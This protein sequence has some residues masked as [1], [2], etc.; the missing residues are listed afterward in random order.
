M[1]IALLTAL[2]EES[3]RASRKA[4][5]RPFVGRSVL[6]HQ[7]DCAR[8]LDCDMVVCM[9]R[10]LGP[11]A[12]VCQHRAESLGMRFRAIEDLRRLSG[13]ISADDRVI[14]IADGLALDI[15]TAQAAIG[16][17]PGVATFPADVAVPLGFERIDAERAWA[18]LLA[19]R[20][21]AVERLSDLPPDADAA[22][23]LLRIALQSGVRT[24]PLDLST[25]EDMAAIG[26]EDEASLSARGA[27]PVSFAAPGRAMA[28][29]I[30]IRLARDV[31]GSRFERVPLM[32]AV[33][34]GVLAAILA[35][36]GK[37]L[38][39]LL[40][41]GLMAAALP[42]ADI[43]LRLARPP[44][45]EPRM[46]HATA[47]LAGAG[48]VLLIGLI[49]MAGRVTGS[50]IDLFLPLMLMGLLRIG[51]RIAPIA[52]RPLMSDRIALLAV[53]VPAG[54]LGLLQPVVASLA[55]LALIAIYHATHADRLTAP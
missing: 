40:I 41:S 25:I 19:I 15:E 44:G 36:F 8:A 24:A 3:G 46:W 34:A 4:A 22:S 26:P 11:E 28:E 47:L 31:V 55:L 38:T 14:V 43:V 37:P 10:G 2:A 9:I 51:A 49:A 13:A 12:I 23:A 20:G 45:R 35:V 29:R 5:F 17:K 1:R 21:D 30:G 32:V 27:Q 18:G 33:A 16:G 42:I 39:G 48:D 7:I 53:L 50:W 6:S 54:Y 52:V